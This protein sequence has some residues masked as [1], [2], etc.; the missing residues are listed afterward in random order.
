MA[1]K[2]VQRKVIAMVAKKA[3]QEAAEKVEKKVV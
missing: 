2:M 1:A 3:F